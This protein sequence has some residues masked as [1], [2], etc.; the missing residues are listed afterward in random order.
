[1]KTNAATFRASLTACE[2]ETADLRAQ[3]HDLE[4]DYHDWLEPKLLKLRDDVAMLQRKAARTDADHKH[5]A[6][7]IQHEG[8]NRDNE[9]RVRQLQIVASHATAELQRL[10]KSFSWRVT[11]PFRVVSKLL[12]RN[13]RKA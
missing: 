11:A 6:K 13:G 1:M 8:L 7:R 3:I 10:Q 2:V 9:E 12:R 5:Q 4:L